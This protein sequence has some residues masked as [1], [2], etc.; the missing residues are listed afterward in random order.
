MI[1]RDGLEIVVGAIMIVLVLGLIAGCIMFGI[2]AFTTKEILNVTTELEIVE[3]KDYVTQNSD[4]DAI[5]LH[6]KGEGFEDGIYVVGRGRD[7][8]ESVRNGAPT[9][10]IRIYHTW[11]AIDGDRISYFMKHGDTTFQGYSIRPLNEE[12]VCE[13]K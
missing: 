9:V 7:F 1:N 13:A 2:S 3:I 11:D 10:T 12:I 8:I 6:L 4:T 5:I